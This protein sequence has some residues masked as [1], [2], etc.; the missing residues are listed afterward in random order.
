MQRGVLEI[1]CRYAARTWC[2]PALARSSAVSARLKDYA[3]FDGGPPHK[4]QSLCGLVSPG[5]PNI[6]RRI[7]LVMLICWAPLAVLAATQ[8]DLLAADAANSFLLDFGVHARYL[9]AAPLLI[10]AEGVCLPRM[11][12]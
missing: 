7:A 5:R 8:G 12:A 9:V 2:G 11:G 1:G 6:A 10:F 3:L 4:L